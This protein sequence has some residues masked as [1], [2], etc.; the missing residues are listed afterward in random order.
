MPKVNV[1][2][3]FKIIRKEWKWFA[4][5]KSEGMFFY[6]SKPKISLDSEHWWADEIWS[7]CSNDISDLFDIDTPKD[8]KKSLVKREGVK[9]KKSVVAKKPLKRKTRAKD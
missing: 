4:I 3:V 9:V 5:D 1:Q 6:Q 7:E 8:W 2:D